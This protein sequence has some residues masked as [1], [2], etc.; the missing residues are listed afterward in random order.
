MIRALAFLFLAACTSFPQV[1]AVA[2]QTIGARPDLLTASQLQAVL[3]ASTDARPATAQ[4][5][6]DLRD[7]ADA[8]R[9]R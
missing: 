7:R 4:D 5:G 9:A 2:S 8:L 1:D 3:T 6:R